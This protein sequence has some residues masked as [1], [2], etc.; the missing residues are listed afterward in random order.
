MQHP[1]KRWA[2]KATTPAH[3]GELTDY[4]R[5]HYGA[6]GF[7]RRGTIRKS[8]LKELARHSDPHVRGM[9]AFALN[10]NEGKR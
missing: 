1:P 4:V 8:A 5:E 6:A 2:S 7:T 9:A 3:K 10:I